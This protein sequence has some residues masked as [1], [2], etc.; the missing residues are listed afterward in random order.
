MARI[1]IITDCE[2]CT[3]YSEG[4]Q[5]T[6]CSEVGATKQAYLWVKVPVINAGAPTV[7]Y[8]YYD[9]AQPDNTAYVGDIGSA[10]AT[11]VW[12]SAE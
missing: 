11:A 4:C 2:Q 9:A 10:P 12:N 8:L 5:S 7:L 6:Y 1:L 3:R